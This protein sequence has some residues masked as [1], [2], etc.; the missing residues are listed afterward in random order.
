[1]ISLALLLLR[2]TIGLIFLAHGSQKLFGLFGGGGLSGTSQMM[3]HIGLQPAKLWGTLSALG[4]FVG[5][6]LLVLGWFTPLAA[7]LIIAIMLVAIARV[8]WS[9]GFWN[10]KGGFEFNL[11]LL[12][13]AVTLGLAGAGA[14]SLDAL[15]VWSAF[16]AVLFLI[17][18]LIVILLV[19]AL[20]FVFIPWSSK[21][22]H[23]LGA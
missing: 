13:M 7:L 21:R 18:L 23:P 3:G 4:E 10:S 14:Y 1:M 16:N 9:K 5:G 2:L 22:G 11:A 12:M 6:L 19:L 17:G 20:H 15:L 8:H